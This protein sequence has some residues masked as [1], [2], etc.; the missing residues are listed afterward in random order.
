M[1]SKSG[2]IQNRLICLDNGVW[3]PPRNSDHPFCEIIQ[4]PRPRNIIHGRL[5]SQVMIYVKISISA[6][7]LFS[8]ENHLE[9]AVFYNINDSLM[10]CK[11][12]FF[13]IYLANQNL[14]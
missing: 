1:R 8:Q 9:I 12:V 5:I 3:A 6:A 2:L 14:L 7:T 13:F 10:I 4:C 11:N